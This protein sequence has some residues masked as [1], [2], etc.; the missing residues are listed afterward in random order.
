[1]QS[2]MLTRWM[3]LTKG[4]TCSALFSL[5]DKLH[6]ICISLPRIPLNVSADVR[7]PNDCTELA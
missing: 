3:Q 6:T 2:S 7:K 5:R 1:M 4:W